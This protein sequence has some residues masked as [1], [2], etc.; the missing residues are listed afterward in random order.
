MASDKGFLELRRIPGPLALQRF[1]DSRQENSNF[2]FSVW[3]TANE[4]GKRTLLL[5]PTPFKAL[6]Y[7]LWGKQCQSHVTQ[8]LPVDCGETGLHTLARGFTWGSDW[9]QPTSIP[10]DLWAEPLTSA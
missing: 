2:S 10:E 1:K 8:H 3:L 9:A 5:H 6:V 7:A 4:W